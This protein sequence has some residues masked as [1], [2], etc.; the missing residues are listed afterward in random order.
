MSSLLT[1]LAASDPANPS[2][3]SNYQV[4]LTV[5]IAWN[6]GVNTA[7]SLRTWTDVTEFVELDA[8][9]TITVGRGDERSTADAN[10]LTLTFDN[11]D[12]R[13]TAGKTNGPYGAYVKLGRPIRVVADPVDGS[14]FIEFLGFVDEWPTEWSEGTDAYARAVVS[15]SSRLSRIGT[16]A[17]L[18]SIVETAI[19][20]DGPAAYYT[21]G[22]PAGATQANDTSGNRADPL[23]LQGDPN[24][25]VVFG[26]AT[27][28]GTDGLTAATFTAAGQYL[29][30]SRTST[31][32]TAL[33]LEGF[34]SL[35]STGTLAVASSTGA[36]NLSAFAGTALARI[37]DSGVLSGGF[38]LND[39]ET[40]H[41]LATGSVGGSADLYID[42]V[43]ADTAAAPTA[44]TVDSLTVGQWS[45]YTAGDTAT[46][47]H[48]AYGFSYLNAT[49]AAAY[50]NAGLTGYAGD[51]TS[52]RLVR[53]AGYAGIPS[54]EVSTETG[55][56]TVQHIDTTGKQVVELMRVMETTEGG[57][58][59][60]ERDGILTL[61]N[62]ASRLTA[63]S[64][65]TLDMAQQM[66]EQDYL[67]KMDRTGI[68][69]DVTA[70]DVS[71]EFT[72]HVFDD[73]SQDDNGFATMSIETAAEDNDEPAFQ[74]GWALYKYK[75]PRVRVPSLTVNCLAQVGKTPNCATVLSATVGTKITVS[76]HPAQAAGSTA[77]YFVEGYTRT[78]GPESCMTTFNVSATSPEDQTYVCGDA[79]RGVIGTN[80]IAL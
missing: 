71:G 51:L 20:A 25:P 69:N 4:N 41:L 5:E 74:A 21:L 54:T 31:T 7:S 19:L 38:G 43:L 58:L 47:A 3:P 67:P 33:W 46:V 44:I 34:V 61:R 53:Y 30:T 78:Y 62:R 52:A 64:A 59:Y 37:G 23:T 68:A 79:S 48:V 28:P 39:G 2:A 63:T 80:P 66:V 77:T 55:Q 75:D 45:S 36:T 22:E 60:D 24:L 72:A 27:G 56:T 8:G 6:A 16:Q 70:T 17:S 11:K 1:I 32:P 29:A 57:V 50:A 14:P 26:T 42:G 18:K 12:G 13:F 76:N 9:I 73:P 35:T 15:A 10:H 49:Q 65:F 40:H